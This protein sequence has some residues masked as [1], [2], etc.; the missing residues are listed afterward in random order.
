MFPQEKFDC[1]TDDSLRSTAERVIENLFPSQI[2]SNELFI[3]FIGNSPSSVYT[4]RYPK[5]LATKTQK[6]GGRIFLFKCHLD[7]NQPEQPAFK[8]TFGDRTIKSITCSEHL[9]L[10]YDELEKNLPKNYWQQIS[11]SIYP[12]KLIDERE[13]LQKMEMRIKKIQNRLEKQAIQN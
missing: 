4:Y 12:D 1:E 5:P 7:V 9:W 6:Y 2:S 13:I 8:G 3:N 10:T 11:R